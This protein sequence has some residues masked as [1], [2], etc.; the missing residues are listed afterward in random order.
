MTMLR[1]LTAISVLIVTLCL[2]AWPA[3][4]QMTL[5]ENDEFEGERVF[6]LTIHSL[7]KPSLLFRCYAIFLLS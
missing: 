4:A 1:L 2:T 3:M 5:I 7:D 6:L